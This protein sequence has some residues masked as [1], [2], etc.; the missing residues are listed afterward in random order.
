MIIETHV[1]C[2]PLYICN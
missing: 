2:D 1:Y